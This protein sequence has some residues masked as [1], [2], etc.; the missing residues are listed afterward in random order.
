MCAEVDQG[1]GQGQAAEP[2]S[3]WQ[4]NLWQALQGGPFLQTDHTCCGTLFFIFFWANN[5]LL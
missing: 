3:I 5:K 1:K 4:R 2:C